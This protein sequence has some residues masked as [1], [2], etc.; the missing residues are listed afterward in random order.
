[1]ANARK[2]SSVRPANTIVT[3]SA[4]HLIS[5]TQF[6]KRIGRSEQAVR[7]AIELGRVTAKK[8]D[9]KLKIDPV[10]AEREW[11]ENAKEKNRPRLMIE[12]EEI[13]ADDASFEFNEKI[14][15]ENASKQRRLA[16]AQKEFWKAKQAQLDYEEKAGKYVPIHKV[17]REAFA[18]SR[19]VR[20]IIL[21]IPDRVSAEL[22][23]IKDQVKMH[24][25]LTR[26][27]NTAL[28]ELSHA[29]E[30]GKQ[31]GVSKSVQRGDKAGSSTHGKRVGRQTQNIISK[32]K[33]R[34]RK[35]ENSKNPVSA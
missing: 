28:Q 34:A 35:M 23:G 8:V 5:V 7:T 22:V 2:P 32:G 31:G 26:E 30:R 21:S 14:T 24:C 17:Q 3:T 1:M 18:V 4:R 15:S 12:N 13:P 10:T 11:E 16:E 19:T 25:V 9:G 20:D 6:A 33:R 29:L 27:L